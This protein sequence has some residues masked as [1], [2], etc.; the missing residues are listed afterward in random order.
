MDK[1]LYKICNAFV[2]PEMSGSTYIFP[3][4]F[5]KSSPIT[6]LG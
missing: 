6:L 5:A 1:T 2:V 4:R 3:A